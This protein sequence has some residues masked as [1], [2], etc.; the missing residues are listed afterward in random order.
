MKLDAWAAQAKVPKNTRSFLVILAP[1]Q[2][3]GNLL[4]Q[5][6]EVT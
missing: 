5:K 1:C 4:T 6:T 2:D 3:V